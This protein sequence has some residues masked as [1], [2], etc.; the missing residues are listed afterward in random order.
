MAD[1]DI[2]RRGYMNVVRN[3]RD[4]VVSNF[5]KKKKKH[6][7][8]TTFGLPDTISLTRNISMQLY[9]YRHL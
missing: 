4:G 2:A 5:K 6:K 3:P 7:K 9:K 8:T 1:N